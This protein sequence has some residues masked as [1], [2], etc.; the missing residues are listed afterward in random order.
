LRKPERS[1]TEER[2]GRQSRG[3]DSTQPL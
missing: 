2:K 1:Q 3:K